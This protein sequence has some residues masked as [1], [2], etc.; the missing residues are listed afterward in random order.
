[1]RWFFIREK[2]NEEE[3]AQFQILAAIFLEVLT[4]QH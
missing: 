4:F 1:M 2:E 3:M